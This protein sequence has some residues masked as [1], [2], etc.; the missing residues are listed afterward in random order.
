MFTDETQNR[1]FL[2]QKTECCVLI[3]LKLRTRDVVG[4]PQLNNYL[5]SIKFHFL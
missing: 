4:D 1:S 3:N 5:I 2:T